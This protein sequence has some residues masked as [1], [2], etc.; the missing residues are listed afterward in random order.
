MA[1]KTWVLTYDGLADG[2]RAYGQESL[3]TLGNGYIGW[4]GAPI[5][6]KFD[7][8]HYPG[9]Y[10]AGV[11]NQTQTKV[12]DRDVVNEDMV[13]MPNPQLFNFYLAGQQV[14]FNQET[15]VKRQVS[16]DFATGILHETVTLA[17]SVGQ[18][19][20]DWEK[21]VDPVNYHRFALSVNVMADFDTELRVESLIDGSILN[22]NVERY[23]AFD[24]KEYDVTAVEGDLLLA[25]TRSNQLDLV[26]GAKTYGPTGEFVNQNAAGTEVQ[27]AIMELPLKAN[28]PSRFTKVMAIATSL[29][30]ATPKEQVLADLAS[31]AE[32]IRQASVDYWQAVWQDADIVLDSDDPDM[33][34]MIRMNVFHIRQA[35][36]HKANR[37]L[38]VSV[39]SRGLTGEGYRGHIFWDELFVIPYYAANDP[40]TARDL[41]QYRVRRLNAA[42]ANA[43]VD[44]EQG[45]MYPWQSG[46]YGDEQAQYIHLNTVNNEWEPDNS[47]RQ[48][49]ISLA[50]AYNMWI[51]TQLTNDK[52]FM[53]DGGLAVLLETSKFWLN[54]A[55]LGTDGR[56]HIAGVMGPDEYHEAY[57][58]AK[59]GGITDNAYTNIMVAWSLR[60]LLELAEDSALNFAKLAAEHDFDQ[61]LLDKAKLVADKLALVIDDNGV[62]AQYAGYFDL[63]EVDFAAYTEKY[64]DIHRIDRLLKAEG[65]SPDDY[66]VAKQADFLMAIY[67]L[68]AKQVATLIEQLGYDLPADWLAINKDYYQARTVHGSTTSRPVFAG[69]DVTLNEKQEALEYLTTAIGSDFYD[70]QGGTTAEGVHIGVM[71]ETLEVI[72]NEFGGVTLR[73]GQIEIEPNLPQTWRY[74][75]FT[76]FFRGV[77]LRIE[78]TPDT[79]TVMADQALTV[80][81]LG[82]SVQLLPNQVT[83]ITRGE[84]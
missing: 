84:K 12:A 59:E 2:K 16:L 54:K 3:L 49:H 40:Q 78:I 45:A 18:L 34:K 70:I 53:N 32:A 79:V 14:E 77:R 26:I 29:E 7:D 72:Q 6:A 1:D 35:A 60:W 55:E 36:Q 4:R 38:D 68:G 52:T 19:T 11:F 65:L 43:Q 30:L 28:Q 50:I 17:L 41:L 10:V 33:Q 57:P 74:L 24:S 58:G 39:G 51:Y 5:F 63:K 9:L 62:V 27:M 69:I 80:T 31:S 25:K 48:R 21:Y 82:Q 61:D 42:K 64:G 83:E 15:I 76:Q 44:D 8:A 75:K 20:V 71:G 46:Q 13:N 66:Q 56:Y 37:D 22:Q 67:N 81:I 23:R 73:D 47:R